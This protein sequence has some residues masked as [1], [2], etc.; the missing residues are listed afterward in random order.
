MPMSI[1]R[2]RSSP[3]SEEDTFGCD[4]DSIDGRNW[5]KRFIRT[6]ER[7]SLKKT[8]WEISLKWRRSGGFFHL[9]L[10]EFQSNVFCSISSRVSG[11]QFLGKNE[12]R[13]PRITEQRILYFHRMSWSSRPLICCLSDAF[14]LPGQLRPFGS[15]SITEQIR[16]QRHSLHRWKSLPI[17]AILMSTWTEREIRREHR[18][19]LNWSFGLST[20]REVR[21]DGQWADWF[22]ERLV[23]QEKDR[24]EDRD[25]YKLI[26]LNTLRWTAN[27]SALIVSPIYFHFL[28][29]NNRSRRLAN[30]AKRYRTNSLN[31]SSKLKN[32]ER[33]DDLR[34][35]RTFPWD[36]S[37]KK[38]NCLPEISWIERRKRENNF[39]C[40]FE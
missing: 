35:F 23:E 27:S 37:T 8:A 39:Q 25:R 3:W 19:R 2:W 29:V 14:A 7:T 6:K 4:E 20:I 28:S 30:A 1:R 36:L 38:S 5:M 24:I 12:G 10:F 26:E 16:D 40:W 21:K 18:W 31:W 32:D 34:C 17:D 11:R 22:W 9:Q 33:S 15:R 13:F